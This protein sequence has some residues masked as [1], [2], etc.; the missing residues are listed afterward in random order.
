M[1]LLQILRYFYS[2]DPEQSQQQSCNKLFGLKQPTA[3][4]NQP[5]DAAKQPFEIAMSAE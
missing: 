5:S 2:N 4:L 3:T 1:Q